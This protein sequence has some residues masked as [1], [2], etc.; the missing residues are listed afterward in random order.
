MIKEIL[1]DSFEY[2]RSNFKEL[3]LGSI[4][5]GI[6]GA[7]IGALNG[8]LSFKV[9]SYF[10]NINSTVIIIFA[11]LIMVAIIV[12]L[13]VAGYFVR[14]MKSSV[15]NSDKA[16]D[17]DNFLDLIIKGFLFSIGSFIVALIF[18]IVPI[19]LFIIGALIIKGFG[20]VF[21]GVGIV[22]LIISLILLALYQPLAQVNF[23][24]KGFFGFFEFGKIFKMVFNLN[25]IILWLLLILIGVGIGIIITIIALAIHL[26]A[27]FV[28]NLNVYIF[29][30]TLS[31]F[32]QYFISFYLSVFILRAYSLYY[33][34]YL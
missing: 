3:S 19:I 28:D 4:L 10:F 11:I 14:I 22:L 33:R 21:I 23:S 26:P 12:S 17:W 30:N 8:Y 13:I 32:I 31:S 9:S 34:N 16:P 24:V 27:F 29:L 1:T 2:V 6:F 25:Y 7:M 18:M 5:Y 20:I 15:E